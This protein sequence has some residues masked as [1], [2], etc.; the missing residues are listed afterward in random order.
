MERTEKDAIVSEVRLKYGR[1]ALGGVNLGRRDNPL[2]LA[3]L[4]D[5]EVLGGQAADRPALLVEDRDVELN[6]VDRAAELRRIFR[7]LRE[8]PAIGPQHDGRQCRRN[9]SDRTSHRLL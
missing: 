6:D 8:H 9:K 2:R 5:R 7:L 1:I 4:G 3:V